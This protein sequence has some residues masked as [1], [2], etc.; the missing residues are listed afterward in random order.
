[1]GGICWLAVDNP[2]Q[3][4]RIPIFCGNTELPA[5]YA[6]CGQ[7]HYWP[8]SVLW[9][10]RRANKLA[11]LSWQTTKKGFKE[12]VMKAEDIAFSGLK[13]LEKNPSSAALNNYTKYVFD[14]S[15]EIWKEMENE[16]WVQFGSGF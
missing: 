7:K 13:V 11:T 1:V 8:E 2:A 6:Y 4:P 16:Y 5:A 15:A 10:F 9:T 3:S 12:K 14:R